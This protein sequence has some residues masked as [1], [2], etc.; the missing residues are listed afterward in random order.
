[1][2]VWTRINVCVTVCMDVWPR[3][4]VYMDVWGVYGHVWIGVRTRTDT[5][6][7]SRTCKDGCRNTD[8]Y[9]CVRV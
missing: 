6:E 9:V 5:C 2:G 1:M 4:D 7:D 3:I 8:G